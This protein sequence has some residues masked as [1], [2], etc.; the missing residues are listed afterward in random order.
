MITACYSSLKSYETTICGTKY[1]PCIF[2][3]SSNRLKFGPYMHKCKLLFIVAG[4]ESAIGKCVQQ[5]VSCN[6]RANLYMHICTSVTKWTSNLN[7][8]ILQ[9]LMEKTLLVLPIV[10]SLSSFVHCQ[11]LSLFSLIWQKVLGQ[12]NQ[13]ASLL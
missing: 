5:T 12:V 7:I 9:E 3:R 13:V 2:L 11:L 6:L 8:H 1:L 4:Y 10:L